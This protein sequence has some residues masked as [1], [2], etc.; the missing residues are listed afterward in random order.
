VFSIERV[1]DPANKSLYR[2][3]IPF[4]KGVA[5]KEDK[6]VTLTLAY[7]S[8]LLAA[9]LAVVKIVPKAVVTADAKA[10]GRR[11]SAPARG[12][13]R[14]TARRASR[15]PSSATTPTPAPRRPGPRR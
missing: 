2:Q 1:L 15:S 8:A 14:T 9:R 12:S 10:F 11:R 5:K 3:F 4:I 7:P 13:S 6:M